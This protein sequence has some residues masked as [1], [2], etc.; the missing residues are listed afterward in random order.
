MKR[1]GKRFW[2]LLVTF[3]ILPLSIFLFRYS[4]LK[5][6]GDF[7]VSSDELKPCQAIFVLGGGANVRGTRAGEIW[8]QGMAPVVYCLGR[9]NTREWEMMGFKPTEPNLT[10][11]YVVQAGVPDSLVRNITQGTSTHE[12]RELILAMARK[13]QFQCVIVVT[14]ELHTRRVRQHFKDRFNSAGVDLILVG[15][16]DTGYTSDN[17]WTREDGLIFVNNEY[18]K[19]FYYL[20]RHSR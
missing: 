6:I 16:P 12:E 7:L 11:P 4:I 18:I 13:H 1:P 3:G 10:R 2:V 9:P 5:G 14:S 17:W 20:L 19:L 8:K 15:A